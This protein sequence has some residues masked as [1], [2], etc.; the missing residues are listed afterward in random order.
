MFATQVIMGCVA[1][2][3]VLAD[4]PG[5]Q[6]NTTMH[7]TAVHGDR[8]PG[9]AQ[10]LVCLPALALVHVEP[11]QPAVNSRL[12][13][14]LGRHAEACSCPRPP[15]PLWSVATLSTQNVS[16]KRYDS[17]SDSVPWCPTMQTWL[18]TRQ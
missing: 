4:W 14:D 12:V 15:T 7:G 11:A 5:F 10:H 9:K 13:D 17:C 8:A 18:R 3:A 6:L 1:V 2:L 16:C